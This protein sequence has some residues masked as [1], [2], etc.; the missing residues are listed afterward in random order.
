VELSDR[1][2]NSGY[3]SLDDTVVAVLQGRDE[4][5]SATTENLF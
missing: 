4:L 5:R 1:F 2:G 3:S